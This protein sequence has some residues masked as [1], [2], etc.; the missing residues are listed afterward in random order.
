MSIIA[1]LIS[2]AIP[3]VRIALK[4]RVIWHIFPRQHVFPITFIICQ[5]LVM[6]HALR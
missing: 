3:H 5:Y 6:L 1:N 4:K 2:V